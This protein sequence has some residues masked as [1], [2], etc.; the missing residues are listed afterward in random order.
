MKVL[1]VN[2]Y[3]VGWSGLQNILQLEPLGLELIATTLQSNNDVYILDLRYQPDLENFVMRWQP[4]IVGISCLYTSHINATWDIAFRAKRIKPDIKIVTGGHPPTM[5]PEFFNSPDIDIIVRGDGELSMQDICQT[6]E[7]RRSLESIPG[8][9][10][11]KSGSQFVT[12]HRIQPANLRN[13]PIAKRDL[14][15]INRRNYYLGLQPEIA[16]YELTRGCKF[17]CNFCSIWKFAEGNVRSRT[18]EEAVEEFARIPE[19]RIFVAD[20]HFFFDAEFMKELGKALVDSGL[21]KKIFVQSRADVIAENPEMIDIWKDA[22][23]N[24]VFIGFDGHSK[25]RLRAVRKSAV[26]DTNKTAINVLAQRGIEIRGNLIVDPSFSLEDFEEVR[27]YIRSTNYNFITFC[28]TTPFPGTDVWNKR[29]NEVS[30]LDFSL[31][32]LAHAVMKTT[33][34]LE[35]FYEQ[36]V[37]LWQLRDELQPPMSKWD[38]YKLIGQAALNNRGSLKLLRSAQNF[39][40]GYSKIENY[41]ND[42]NESKNLSTLHWQNAKPILSPGAENK[43]KRIFN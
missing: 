6:L 12:Q 35:K 42:H 25:T 34:P 33:L 30:T 31:Y 7:Q 28:I 8:I 41:I 37:S 27:R 22:G 3:N 40:T 21:N 19:E 29:R 10:I 32:D 23:L 5:A 9:V 39:M 16:N 24:T 36:Y 1:L 2:P 11:N 18:V 13:T 20:D 17:R 4:D 14:P 15:G 26:P 38:L 43:N